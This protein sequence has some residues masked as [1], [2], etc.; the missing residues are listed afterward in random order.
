MYM[1]KTKP[2]QHQQE[3]FDE[4]WDRIYY[5]LFMEMGLGKSK[6]IIDT[7]GKLKL[8]DKIDSALIVAPKGVYDNWAKQ[9]IPNHLPDEYERFI[10]SWKP[11]KA[12][13]F[14]N[15]MNK[16]VF[17]TLPGIKFFLVNVDAFSTER[18]KK[19]AYYFLRK[20]LTTLW[21]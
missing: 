20:T 13:A 5:A 8:E 12:K 19:A 15:D 10:V 6:V 9:E 17:E 11:T 2:F 1:F 21:L 16:L 18:G 3:I 4:S 7:I 14:Q